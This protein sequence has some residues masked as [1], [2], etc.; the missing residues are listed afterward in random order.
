MKL[1]SINVSSLRKEEIGGRWVE[2]GIFK[3]PVD[4]PVRMNRT[5]VAGDQQGDVVYHGGPNQAAYAYT[6]ENLEYWKHQTGHTEWG[7]GI[8]GEN[9]TVEGLPDTL[10]AV[11][12]TLDLEAVTF[13]V[14]GARIPCATL[15]HAVG[16]PNFHE[17]FMASGRTGFYLRVLREGTLRAGEAIRHTPF[18]AGTRVTIARL[19]EIRRTGIASDEEV[20]SLLQNPALTPYMRDWVGRHFHAAPAT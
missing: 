16:I 4:G 1:L 5:L 20:L 13:Q 9:L 17:P 6:V 14:T 7:P 2:T 19:T 11:G 12:D 15:S 8:F 18:A 10:V 3:K